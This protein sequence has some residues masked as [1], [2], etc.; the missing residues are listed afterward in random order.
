MIS[1]HAV[2][3]FVRAA[4]SPEDNLLRCA[5]LIARVAYPGLDPAPWVAEV[6]RMGATARAHVELGL[7]G[8][9]PRR[10]RLRVVTEFMYGQLGFAGN[11]EHY[12]DPR[13]S[14]LNDVIARR[15]GIPITLAVVFM[16]VAARAGLTVEGVN[17]PGHFLVRCL[18]ADDE[19]DREP[20]LL[21]PFHGGA[22]LSDRECT[23]LLRTHVGL[24][25][26]LEPSM[27]RPATK[28]DILLRMLL[29]LKRAYVRLRSFP[30]AHAV[31]ELL[32][33]FDP[34]ALTELRDRGLLAYQQGSWASALRDLEEWLRMAP[35][36]TD[37]DRQVREQ[38]WDH[39]KTLRRRLAELN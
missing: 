5:L 19:G 29:N 15:T 3:E 20:L 25:A 36:A 2:D 32:V 6:E 12:D 11:R 17:F 18:A 34:S 16:E 31:A 10:T 7:G 13:N 37:D 21:D 1:R 38:V 4:A 27:L 24:E 8:R 28:R 39:V 14:L 33:A 9:P 30:Q 23:R 26:M 35:A 22:I